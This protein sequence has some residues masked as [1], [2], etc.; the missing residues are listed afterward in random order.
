MEGKKVKIK[1]PESRDWNKSGKFPRLPF[2]RRLM[3]PSVLSHLLPDSVR[4][5]GS[6]Y[7]KAQFI[8]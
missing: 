4:V 6:I 1:F 3:F 7:V 8:G 2:L 5:Y